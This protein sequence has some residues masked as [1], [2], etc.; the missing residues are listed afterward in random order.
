MAEERVPTGV[1]GLDNL[2]GGGLRQGKSYLISGETGT[3]KTTFSME[4]LMKGL[5]LG[6]SGVYVTVDEKPGDLIEDAKS[7]GFEITKGLDQKKIQILDYSAHF[8]QIR[9]KGT[10][11]D[12]RKIVGDLNKYIRQIG[13]KRLVIDPIAPFVVKEE[14]MWEVRSYIRSLFYALDGLGTTTLLGSAIPTGTSS[15]SQFGVE[16][17]YASGV[18]VLSIVRSD[19]MRPRRIMVVRKMRGS[20]HTLEPYVYEFEHGKGIVIQ[21]SL[22]EDFEL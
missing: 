9:E 5:E 21:Q 14:K 2:I 1:E 4:F 7:F 8:D 20:A 11:I 15:L 17:F 22:A 18:I 12:V 10:D 19:K 13:A 6:E 16:E 3:G